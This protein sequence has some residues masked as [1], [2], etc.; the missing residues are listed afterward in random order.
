M[1]SPDYQPM[2]RIM[3]IG[4]CGAGK[5]T[6]AK[7]IHDI[8]QLPLIHLDKEYW[9]PG[10]VEPAPELWQQKNKELIQ[11][12]QWI[13]DGNY[14]S[15]MTERIQRADTIVDL[16]VPSWKALYRV[17]K[18]VRRYK[19]QARPDMAADC[20]ERIN[21]AFLHYVLM[22]NLS[23]KPQNLK[24]LQAHAQGKTIYTL[25]SDREVS[26]FL[27]MLSKRHTSAAL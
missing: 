23:R 15:S 20:Q 16:H 12:E 21:L 3:I 5:S 19:G 13:I 9:Q 18:R 26:Q 7:K 2:K 24:R 6:L 22:F 25:K 11:R 1:Q 8:T 27:E 17:L 4:S 14:G 10:W